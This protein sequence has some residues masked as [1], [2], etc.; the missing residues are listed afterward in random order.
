LEPQ[1]EVNKIAGGN[2]ELPKAGLRPSGRR[3]STR[4]RWDRRSKSWPGPSTS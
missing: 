1:Q 4:R 2:F 3:R